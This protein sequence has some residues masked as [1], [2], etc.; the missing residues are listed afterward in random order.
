MRTG[1]KTRWLA[2]LG[3]LA[4]TSVGLYAAY[5]TL[6]FYWMSASR[7][8]FDGLWWKRVQLYGSLTVISGVAWILSLIVVMRPTTENR[9]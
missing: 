5:E 4:A 2:A 8:E 3:W 1:E 7:P 6:F 9:E